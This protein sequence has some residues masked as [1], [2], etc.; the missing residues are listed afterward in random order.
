MPE[1]TTVNWEQ[2]NDWALKTYWPS[3]HP[4]VQAMRTMPAVN[5]MSTQ[6]AIQDRM[7]K[8]RELTERGFNIDPEIMVWDAHPFFTMWARVTFGGPRFYLNGT[9]IIPSID[10]NDYPPFKKIAPPPPPS[11][12][13]TAVVGYNI[14]PG[15]W[16]PGK[17]RYTVGPSGDDE[18]GDGKE[19]SDSRG[20]F[21][22]FVRSTAVGVTQ[23][24]ELKGK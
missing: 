14:A 8:G 12:A 10:P 11:P 3:F 6:T 4:D 24:W 17:D 20:T 16:G 13:N 19:Y 7:T 1:D 5:S 21:V 15:L 18:Y 9:P 23:W 2:A 22:K